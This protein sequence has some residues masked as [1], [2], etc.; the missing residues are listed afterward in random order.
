MKRRKT[1]LLRDVVMQYL[2]QEGLET[3][4][5]QYRALKVWPQIAGEAVMKYCTDFRLS[6]DTLYVK[7]SSPALRQNLS[8]ARTSLVQKINQQVGAQVV[9]NIVFC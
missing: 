5:N 3:P 7:L 9:Q 6:N 2:R 1:E 4:L 8:M